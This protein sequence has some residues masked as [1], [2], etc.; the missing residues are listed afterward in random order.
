MP[1]GPRLN[2]IERNFTTRNSLGIEGVASSMAA[3]IC[4]VVTTVTPRAFYWVYMTWIYYDFYENS[5]IKEQNYKEFNS[6]LKKQDYYFVLANLLVNPLGESNMGGVTQAGIDIDNNKN[7][8]YSYNP[9]Y[10]NV[11]LGGMQY[12]NAGCLLM[13][14]ITDVDEHNNVLPFP[15]LTPLGV[16]QAKAFEK[17]VKK[18]QYYSEYRLKDKAVPQEVLIEYGKIVNFGLKRF[19]ECKDII[20]QR[21]LA[22]DKLKESM[23]YIKYL[24][25]KYDV[26]QMD[27]SIARRVLF[28][29]LTETGRNIQIPKRL[30]SISDAWEI[31]IGRQYFVA[32]LEM[33]WKTML[34]EIT[35]PRTMKN[36]IDQMLSEYFYSWDL[37]KKLQDIIGKCKMDYEERE[38]AFWE[39]VHSSNAED[40]IEKGLRIILTIYNWLIGRDD[41]GEERA[42]LDY[43][44][45]TNSISLTEFKD[46]VDE[47][48]GRSI[49]DF[50]SFVMKEWLIKQHYETAFEKMLQGR[51]GFYY[52][53]IGNSYV[54]RREFDLS[55][56]GIRLVQLMQVMI[57]LDMLG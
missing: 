46:V 17:I 1:R 15:K 38:G 31:V 11:R 3:D 37:N 22:Y 45:D 4:P 54:Q 35:I 56:K 36:W 47:Y 29:H 9:S 7:G 26:D 32:G 8:M 19:G 42:L 44:M 39:V 6:F 16:K 50:L 41:F 57:D 2:K 48:R 51:D 33:I 14:F 53:M 25:D 40:S 23:E 34:E 12:Y 20:S 24:F 52:E 30:K 55:F 18:T 43:G 49:K 21:L 27:L 28:D 5:G 10:L 13:G